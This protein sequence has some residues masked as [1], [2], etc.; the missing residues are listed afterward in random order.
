[1][2]HVYSA[3]DMRYTITDEV[4]NNSFVVYTKI[5]GSSFL[6]VKMYS[7]LWVL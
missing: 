4:K 3:Q 5:C 1:M 6:V 2:K 7:L